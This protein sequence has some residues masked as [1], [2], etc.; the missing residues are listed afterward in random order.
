M[1][2]RRGPKKKETIDPTA[3]SFQSKTI[4]QKAYGHEL[5][6]ISRSAA[7]VGDKAMLSGVFGAGVTARRP[8]YS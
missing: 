4:N 3:S 1:Q 6:S 5:M 2:A 7:V 8:E